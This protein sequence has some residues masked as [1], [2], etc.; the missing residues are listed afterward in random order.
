MLRH[1][2]KLSLCLIVGNSMI[3]N[4]HAAKPKYTFVVRHGAV[5]SSWSGP[6]EHDNRS[7][8]VDGSSIEIPIIDGKLV[9]GGEDELKRFNK[10]V[11]KSRK[12]TR[13]EVVA[14]ADAYA[15]S[16]RS[17][18]IDNYTRSHTTGTVQ[19]NHS[20]TVNL[21][22]NRPIGTYRL[23]CGAKRLV[24]HNPGGGY[25][26]YNKRWYYSRNWSSWNYSYFYRY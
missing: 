23:P 6:N 26:F 11:R 1:I 3:T 8:T 13:R 22:Y 16:H 17:T 12:E 14:S 10:T 4:V 5:H 20:G 24:Y 19:H 7:H 18:K 9:P 21:N 25:R 2:L 15:E